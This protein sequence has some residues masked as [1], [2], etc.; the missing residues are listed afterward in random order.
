MGESKRIKRKIFLLIRE[1]IGE[2]LHEL[3]Q[4]RQDTVNM[5]GWPGP[6]EYQL[7]RAVGRKVKLAQAQSVKM[8]R[9]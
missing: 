1:G 6:F 2:V 4:F 7:G 3:Q 9:D 8:V 5:E